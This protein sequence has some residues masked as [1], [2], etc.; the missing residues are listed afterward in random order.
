MIHA[1]LNEDLNLS[2]KSARWVPKLLSE[3]TKNERVKTCEAF[4]QMV[5]HQALAMLDQIVTMDESAVAFH[6]PPPPPNQAVAGKGSLALSR[7]RCG[8][9]G[10]RRWSW[11]SLTP[12]ASSKPI[13]KVFKKKRLVMATGDWGFHW[14]NA[15]MHTA[16]IVTD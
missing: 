11:P 5:H 16:A 3:E 8:P 7:P 10:V 14:D 15:P 2:K 4:L 6:T 9:A 13:L 12:R 1:T